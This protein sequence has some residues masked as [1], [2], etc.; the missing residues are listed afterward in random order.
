MKSALVPW[1]ETSKDVT[2][3]PTTTTTTKS[4]DTP[5]AGLLTFKDDGFV[6]LCSPAG[7]YKEEHYWFE[8][9]GYRI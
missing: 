9:M 3:S 6:S 2:I 8:E 4:T 7:P 1:K 5:A